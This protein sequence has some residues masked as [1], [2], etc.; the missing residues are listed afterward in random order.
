MHRNALT[1]VELPCG[2]LSSGLGLRA[3]DGLT[4]R[5]FS[6][7]ELLVVV[8]IIALLLSVAL[9]SLGQAREVA[10]ASVCLNNLHSIGQATTVYQADH[11]DFFFATVR[12][13]YPATGM[14][15]YFWGTDSDPVDR[16]ASPLLK[17]LSNSDS[18]LLCPM[19]PWGS[20]VPQG[21]VN[22]PTTNFGYNAWCLDPALWNRRDE[23]G[24]PMPRK[25]ISDIEHP[26]ELF[27]M[28]DSAMYWAPGG[29]PIVQNSTSLDPVKLKFGNRWMPNTTPTTHFR[30]FDKTQALTADGHAQ[31]YDRTGGM[32]KPHDIGFVGKD[33]APH[34][35]Q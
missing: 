18:V 1:L 3:E 2:R 17:N 31:A 29:V 24:K 26:G 8:A 11:R 30:H 7:V 22:E 33:N 15:T 9:P 21:S 25:R 12:Q 4:Q 28:A 34:Y 6:L 32:L 35:D 27:V 5:G 20:Y 13:D 23:A 19:Q 14:R 16:T 10:R